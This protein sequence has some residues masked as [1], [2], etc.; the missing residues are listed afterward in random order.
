MA[1]AWTALV[2]APSTSASISSVCTFDFSPCVGFA[3]CCTFTVATFSSAGDCTSCSPITE[4]SAGRSRASAF[5][6]VAGTGS[7]DRASTRW[8]SFPGLY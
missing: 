3:S 2:A 5:L 7:R 1:A 6:M 8:F 4:S